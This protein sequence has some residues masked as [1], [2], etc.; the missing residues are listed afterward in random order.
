MHPLPAKA[1]RPLSGREANYALAVF[2]IAYVLSFIDRQTLS[3]MVDPIRQDLGLSDI[4]IGLLQGFAFACLYATM[5]V[6]FGMWVDRGSR[7][8]IIIGGVLF[9]SLATAMC[10]ASGSFAQLFAARVGVGVGEA[11]LSPAAHS[12]LADA[13][14][15]HRLARAMA[16]YTLGI[17][18]GG[19][20]ALI[21]GGSVVQLI[22]RSG[23]LHLPVLGTL[24]A[25]QGAFLVVSVPGV[26]VALL[27]WFT[28]EP[29]RTRM[30]GDE[31]QNTGA[32]LG[33]VAGWLRRHRAA[34]LSIH[35]SSASFAIY[36]YGM[37]GWYP[38]LLIRNFGLNAAQA[39]A[40][41]GILY[42]VTGSL[43]SLAGG[44]MA[45]R[46]ALKGRS[47]ANLRVVMLLAAAVLVPATLAPLMPTA[48]GVLAIF[49]PACFLFSGYF[50]CSIAAI[51]L[52]SP[53]AMR[54]TNAALFLV[55]N[56]MMGLTVGM[57]AVPLIDRLAFGGTGHL[58]PALAVIAA[59]SCGAA[60]LAA[61]WGLA[62]YG[63]LVA[64]Q[65]AA[66]QTP[67]H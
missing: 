38:T 20:M 67:V 7:R 37:V 54:G 24:H 8:R 65:E 55:S 12:F 22:A 34:F 6:P 16:I 53:P 11:T 39:G 40:G 66:T 9:W 43:G 27:A 42:L 62:P 48:W 13:F 46:F 58:G 44:T 51:Q 21:I 1:S 33:E 56:S 14:P 25:W 61:R 36:G 63:E 57:L 60:G 15:R 50:G 2:L 5:G 64:Q 18:L 35:V 41:L 32:S 10:G 26:L 17:T 47:D 29:P 59:V 3:L 28:R 45:E 30:A 4:Q 52:A 23:G 31:R 49:A 19:G